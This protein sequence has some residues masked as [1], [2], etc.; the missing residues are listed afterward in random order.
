MTLEFRKAVEEQGLDYDAL[1]TMVRN[2]IAFSF[3]EPPAK[4]T[5]Q[6]DLDAAFRRFESRR[7]PT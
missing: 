2:S 3:A 6:A 7:K 4:K 1:K 5:L